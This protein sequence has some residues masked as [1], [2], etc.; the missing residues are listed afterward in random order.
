M[1]C[2]LVPGVRTPT[3]MA[4]AWARGHRLLKF[5]PAAASGGPDVL[6]AVRGPL[7]QLR[8]CPTGG[9]SLASMAS[10]LALD[11]VRCVGGSWLVRDAD[12]E[13]RDWA[14][15][16]AKAFEAVEVAARAGWRAT[17]DESVT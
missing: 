1:D 15:V 11:N 13:A 6:T 8:F 5:F 12:L 7:P 3:E 9:I 4:S 16:E 17:A 14:S 10:Y 2:P